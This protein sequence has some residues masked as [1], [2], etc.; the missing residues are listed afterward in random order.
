V[1]ALEVR[2]DLLTAFAGWVAGGELGGEHDLIAVLPR[3]HP[4]TQPLLRFF[5]LVIVGATEVQKSAN[6]SQWFR[7]HSRID[8]VAAVLKKVIKDF[9]GGFLVTG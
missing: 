5:A 3:R 6:C 2:L 9:K 1:I 4:F 8:E 7:G